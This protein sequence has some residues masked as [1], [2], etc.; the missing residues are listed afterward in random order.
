MAPKVNPDVPVVEVAWVPSAVPPR[1]GA[2]EV[3]CP[4]NEKGD[5]ANFTVPAVVPAPVACG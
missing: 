5:A 3:L 2:V 1:V 4:P